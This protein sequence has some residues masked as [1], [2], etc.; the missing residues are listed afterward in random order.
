MHRV[1]SQLRPRP[2]GASVVSPQLRRAF[3]TGVSWKV[4]VEVVSIVSFC[5]CHKRVPKL[6][7]NGNKWTNMN[8]N[9][10]SLWRVIERVDVT[11]LERWTVKQKPLFKRVTSEL[12]SP[13]WWQVRWNVSVCRD[14]LSPEQVTSFDSADALKGR[15]EKSQVVYQNGTRLTWLIPLEALQPFSGFLTRGVK[16]FFCVNIHTSGWKA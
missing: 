1:A 12:D 9:Q 5:P 8:T 16:M 13:V 10:R 2:V 11:S 6:V 7:V 15:G 3:R 4:N 14:S